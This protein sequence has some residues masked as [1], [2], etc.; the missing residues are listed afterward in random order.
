[1]LHVGDGVPP[2]SMWRASR[3]SSNALRPC[4]PLADA[5]V[6]A[7]PQEPAPAASPAGDAVTYRIRFAPQPPLFLSGTEPALLLD[8]LRGLGE[9]TVVAHFDEVPTLEEADPENCHLSWDILLTTDGGPCCHQG[10]LC[11]CRGYQRPSKSM[12][13]PA[14]TL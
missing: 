1:M 7:A 9:C 11:L 8:E 12:T 5:I 14:T 13:F 2:P 6:A 3:T 4:S 10:C